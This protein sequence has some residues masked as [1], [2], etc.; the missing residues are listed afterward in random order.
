MTSNF[1]CY[2]TTCS[3]RAENV[4]RQNVHQIRETVFDK[5]DSFAKNYTI[6]QK[7]FQNLATIDFE[8]VCVQE[9]TFRDTNTTT[10]IRKQVPMFVSFSSDL[11]E[12]PIF[13]CNS[14][15]HHLVAAFIGA[16]EK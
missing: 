6:E 15:P 9:E 12:G 3:G 14:D 16:V 2:L 5:L 7:L 13:L 11:V 8:S 4:Y 10:W 1:E